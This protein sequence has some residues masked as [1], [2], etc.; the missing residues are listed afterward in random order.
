MRRIVSVY[1][2]T[3]EQS[4]LQYAPY[5]FMDAAISAESIYQFGK[6]DKSACKSLDDAVNAAIDDLIRGGADLPYSCTVVAGLPEEG[7]EIP[8]QTVLIQPMPGLAMLKNGNQ[9]IT[10]YAM[11]PEGKLVRPSTHSA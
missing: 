6:G 10:T 2:F 9:L 11:S 7:D 8:W 4:Q 3:D 5:A 1:F